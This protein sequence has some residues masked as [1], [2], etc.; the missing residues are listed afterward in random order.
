MRLCGLV[1]LA[2]EDGLSHSEIH[3]SKL[4]RSSPWLIAAYHV[5]HLLL[6]P[7]HP[8]NAL[9]SLDRSHYQCS[10]LGRGQPA[11]RLAQ[12]ALTK[13]PDHSEKNP[14][15]ARLRPMAFWLPLTRAQANPLFPIFS[16]TGASPPPETLSPKLVTLP[17]TGPDGGACRDRTGDLKLAKLPLSQLS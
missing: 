17:A 16:L 10:P 11:R 5:L 14:A 3:G 9:K 12:R 15:P 4:V 8:P 6:P 7:R 1:T 13:R 2:I